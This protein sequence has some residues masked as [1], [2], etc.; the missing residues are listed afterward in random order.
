MENRSKEPHVWP[1]SVEGEDVEGVELHF[2]VMVS[3]V[4]V[5]RASIVADLEVPQLAKNYAQSFLPAPDDLA[6]NRRVIGYQQCENGSGDSELSK[7]A[8][9]SLPQS[10]RSSLERQMRELR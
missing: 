2:V 1:A 4:V 9:W 7:T 10:G 8:G 3:E 6:E 5:S